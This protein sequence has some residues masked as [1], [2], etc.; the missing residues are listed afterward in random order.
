MKPT[1]IL[2]TEVYRDYFLVSLRE[3]A[4]GRV[5]HF[6]QFDG[7]RLDV[8]RL[9]KLI[10][11]MRLVTFNGNNFD[12]PL[13]SVALCGESCERLKKIADRIILNNVKWWTLDIELVPCDHVD[14]IEVAPGIAS[15]KLYGG[16]LHSKR[17]QDLPIDPD[18][19]IAPE[20][21]A[22]LRSYCENDLQ[23]TLDLFNALQPQLDLRDRMSA[24]YGID[25]RSK[26]D[27]QIAEAVIKRDV[28][29]R[30][31]RLEKQDPFR[32]AGQTFY[33]RAPSFIR[34]DSALMMQALATAQFAVFTVA[35]NG[36][37]RMPDDIASL[38][39]QIGQGVYRMGMGGLHSSEKSVSYFTDDEHVLID[40]DVASYYP[41]II[42]NCGLQPE[43][44]G[45]DFAHVYRELVAM[46]LKAKAAGDKVTA[47]SLKI[48]INGA[49]GKLGSPYS[50]LYS[51]NVLI[52]VTLT[53]QLCLLMLI[54]ALEA[55]GIPVVSANTDGVVIRCPRKLLP[56]LDLIVWDWEYRT[57]FLTEATDYRSLHCRDV[58][59]YIA[60][61]PDKTAK[62]K[63]AYAPAGL[64][65]NPA[66]E[67]V[68]QAVTKYLF[69]G[70]PIEDYIRACTDVRKFVAVRTVKG[71]AVKDGQ[72]L[73]KAIRWY[74][75]KGVTGTINYKVNGYTVPKT[76]GAKPLMEL[77]DA[78][79]DDVDFGWYVREANEQLELLGLEVPN[80]VA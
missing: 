43:A 50:A 57:G 37:V 33:Y 42:L 20:Q 61:K 52:Q 5:H 30:G 38:K 77:P 46:R 10:A 62:V 73:G 66:C 8:K 71:G 47:D 80:Y 19:S 6:E 49:F 65:K 1:A 14:L 3:V 15:L 7:Q 59:N 39:V 79:P 76:E 64:Q 31:R 45:K 55:E 29:R 35:N 74:Y 18:A 60:I 70:T 58:N 54:E 53:G 44:M 75:A 17:M 9:G 25:L 63:G 68:T 27:A 40:R 41:A 12:L 48:T 4:T 13:V 24:A 11:T 16:R 78:L 69:D 2:D 28:Q 51:P 21:R 72:Y 34:F 36:T 26:S 22:V 23:T 67:V 56:M 32:L